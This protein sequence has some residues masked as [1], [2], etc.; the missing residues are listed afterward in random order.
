M[1]EVR[2]PKSIFLPPPWRETASPAPYQRAYYSTIRS[3]T[4]FVTEEKYG[5]DWWLHVSASHP[6]SVPSW[7]EMCQIKDLFI[8][9][10]RKAIQVHPP[11]KEYF[12]FNPYVLHLW[13]NLVRDLLPNFLGPEGVI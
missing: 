2:T 10:D 8:G 13:H 3:L 6:S 12:N 5:D 9:K 7:K 1:T 4:V 11:Q